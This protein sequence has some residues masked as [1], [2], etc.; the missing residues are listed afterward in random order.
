MKILSIFN[1]NLKTI[2]RNLNYFIVLFICPVILIIIAGAML[3]SNNVNN[4]KIGLIN[5][6]PNYNFEIDE[7]NNIFYYE[8]LNQCLYDLRQLKTSS[9]IYI[10]E[11]E[12]ETNAYKIDIYL[13]NTKNII[14]LYAKQFILQKVI[15]EQTS[16]I[17]KAS[18]ELNS[19][20][21]FYSITISDT[22]SKLTEMQ[23]ELDEEENLLLTYQKNLTKIRN[24]FNEI[25]VPL[26]NL[27][28]D[29]KNLQSELS[30]ADQNIYSNIT[31][32]KQKNQDIHSKVILL[33]SFLAE[34]LNSSN[35]AYSASVLNGITTDLDQIN[36]MLDEIAN[37]ESNQAKISDTIDKLDDVIVKLDEVKDALEQMDKDLTIS[38][39]K[40]RAGKTK[41]S[42]FSGKLDDAK[43]EMKTMAEG[44]NQNQL[45]VEFKDAFA[46]RNDPVF[47]I[48]PLLITMII[49]FTSLILS[50]MF[51]L[52]QINQSSYFR[53]IIT[54]ANDINFIL[55]DYL[56]N[57]F[58]VSIQAGVLFLMGIFWFGLSAQSL[59]TPILAIFFA[60]SIFIFI[61]M[62]MG[63]LIQSQNL[64]MLLTI[65]FLLL[66]LIMSDL[67]APS[68][69]AG[70]IVR[71]LINS[72][73][74]TILEQI[75]MNTIVINQNIYSVRSKFYTLLIMFFI[76]FLSS[77]ISKKISK[78]NIMQ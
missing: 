38:I 36:L 48:Y 45:W 5:Q 78:K 28:P 69:L 9:C 46:I 56:V 50:N 1:K 63:Y 31:K 27:E 22:K 76:A 77:Y 64:S 23:N 73:P 18:D 43:A 47:L 75:L 44:I 33:Q 42:E 41:L 61:G 65:F 14:Q 11:D 19:K 16:I 30:N 21:A 17:E 29:I 4:I 70:P 40:I 12:N 74:F 58:F 7:L 55:A 10:R 25:Y 39:E 52:K 32:I 59:Y 15:K 49:T 72:N 62:T 71:I 34:K 24:D 3:N 67:L 54:P 13:D 2:S 20:F 60:C 6:A 37:I 26:K 57:L 66:M 35:Y 8:S 53:D 51:I 68:V